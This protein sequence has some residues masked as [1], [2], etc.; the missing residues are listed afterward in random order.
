MY[1]KKIFTIVSPD[2]NKLKAVIIDGRTT[3]FI[4]KDSD[5]DEAKSQ[6][7]ERRNAKNI[8]LK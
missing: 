3:I 2:L 5:S 4:D 6:Y 8:K 7:Q 1:D